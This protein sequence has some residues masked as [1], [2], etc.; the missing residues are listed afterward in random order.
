MSKV[1]DWNSR[2]HNCKGILKDKCSE[3]RAGQVKNNIAEWAKITS[4]PEVLRSVQGESIELV[5]YPYQHTVPRA[6]EYSDAEIIAIDAEIQKLLEMGVIVPSA[7]EYGEYI[8]NIFTRPKRD[9]K[10]LRVILNL[11][12]LNQDVVYQHFKMDSLNTVLTMMTQNCWM[13]SIDIKQAY[14]HFPLEAECQKLC[15]FIWKGELYQFTCLVQGLSSSPRIF[16]RCLKPMFAALHQKQLL[17]CNFIDDIYLQGDNYND[18]ANNVLDTL[19]MLW[20]LNLTAHPEKP[21]LFPAQTLE[22]LGHILDSTTMT[23]RLTHR[24]V[25]KIKESCQNLLK[26]KHPTVRH[27]AEVIGLMVAAFHGVRWGQLYY[28]QLEL[29]KTAALKA[30]QGNFEKRM[31]LSDLAISDL[32][33]W[34]CNVENASCPVKQGNP[35]LVIFNDASSKGWGSTCNG[36]NTGGVWSSEESLHHII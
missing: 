29:D 20:R 16:C 21:G 3:F 28:R 14:F 6:Y 17:S 11:K 30:Q 7:H 19:E 9:C 12:T 31:S 35:T 10:D 27:V 22:Y 25:T 8:S 34:V 36:V 2:I 32:T 24:R 15:K 23:V 4:D 5:N 1:S 26:T 33:W 13:A 18:C